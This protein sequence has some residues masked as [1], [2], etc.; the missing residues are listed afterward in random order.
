MDGWGGGRS[1][2]PRVGSRYGVVHAADAEER[3]RRDV[4]VLVLEHAHA[5]FLDR[6]GDRIEVSNQRG[7]V[8]KVDIRTTDLRNEFDELV[9]VPNYKVFSEIVLNRSSKVDAPDHFAIEG[10]TA[11]PS[12]MKEVFAQV[13]ADMPVAKEPPIKP[14]MLVP[15]ATSMGMWCSSNHRITPTC[16]MPRALPPPN[17]TPIVGRSCAN[18]DELAVISAMASRKRKGRWR[19]VRPVDGM[20]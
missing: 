14:P 3:L 1:P 12:E 8:E 5:A 9:L 11:P 17:A 7:I 10:I 15:A 18:E 4:A 16:A 6:V 13:T 20:A 19:R 2:S